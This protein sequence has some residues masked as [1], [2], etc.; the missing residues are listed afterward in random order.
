MTRSLRNAELEKPSSS[1][2][3]VQQSVISISLHWSVELLTLT[4]HSCSQFS[5]NIFSVVTGSSSTLEQLLSRNFLACRLVYAFLLYSLLQ[6]FV[7]LSLSLL[8]MPFCSL[9]CL[10]S[11]LITSFQFSSVFQ[12]F[13]QLQLDFTCSSMAYAVLLHHS[14][15]CIRLIATF[16]FLLIYSAVAAF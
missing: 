8:F 16:I 11:F 2:V 12:T 4:C 9:Q 15:L 3:L 5:F 6:F 13:C 14:S 10:C 1:I 7:S